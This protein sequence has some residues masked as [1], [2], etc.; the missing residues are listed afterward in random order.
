[1]SKDKLLAVVN[2]FTWSQILSVHYIG[3]TAFIM[4]GNKVKEPTPKT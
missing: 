2:Y 3:G 1:M 4:I